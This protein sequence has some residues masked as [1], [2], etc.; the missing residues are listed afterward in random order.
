MPSV[1]EDIITHFTSRFEYLVDDSSNKSEAFH[2]ALRSFQNTDPSK[3]QKLNDEVSLTNQTS[4]DT[5]DSSTSNKSS[6]C[7]S[8]ALFIVGPDETEIRANRSVLA[9]MSPVL[10]RMLFGVDLITVDPTVPIVW[11]DFDAEVVEAVFVALRQRKGHIYVPSEGVAS[12]RTFLDFIGELDFIQVLRSDI[13]FEEVKHIRFD[14]IWVYDE[15]F[16]EDVIHI[17]T[18]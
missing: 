16:G 13:S 9:A 8:D 7:S 12:A 2:D 1:F 10:N 3:K 14:Q 5:D 18:W 4:T 11:P 15:D 6:A 17:T